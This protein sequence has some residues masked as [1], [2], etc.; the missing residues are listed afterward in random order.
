MSV[1]FRATS[2]LTLAVVMALT[3]TPCEGGLM[4]NMCG[5]LHN[6]F[7]MEGCRLGNILSLQGIVCKRLVYTM[8]KMG[9]TEL[10]LRGDKGGCAKAAH[11]DEKCGWIEWAWSKGNCGT[12]NANWNKCY[13]LEKKR[14]KDGCPAVA[15][16]ANGCPS[17]FTEVQG[18]CFAVVKDAVS[19][20]EAAALCQGLGAQLLDRDAIYN[21]QTVQQAFFKKL[22]NFENYVNYWARTDAAGECKSFYVYSV[23]IGDQMSINH[24]PECFDGSNLHFVCQMQP[25]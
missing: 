1:A 20:D 14:A 13:K 3:L 2:A 6:G 21:D 24:G 19:W 23:A 25:L 11:W 15:P 12:S 8:C 16:V 9:C 10:E 17:G 4:G 22:N 18:Q 7:V 5:S